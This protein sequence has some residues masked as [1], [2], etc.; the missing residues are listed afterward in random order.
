[1]WT[2][3]S[4]SGSR[5]KHTFLSGR[6]ETLRPSSETNEELEHT[7]EQVGYTCKDGFSSKGP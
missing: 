4:T 7:N 1:M 2:H 5:E 6:G 3:Y